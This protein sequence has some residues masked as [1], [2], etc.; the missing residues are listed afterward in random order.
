MKSYSEETWVNSQHSFWD[1]GV[2]KIPISFGHRAPFQQ[3]KLHDNKDPIRL[4]IYQ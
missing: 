2:L 1:F 4:I 3:Y